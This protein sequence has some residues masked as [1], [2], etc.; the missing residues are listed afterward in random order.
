MRSLQYAALYILSAEIVSGVNVEVCRGERN[1]LFSNPDLAAS[2]PAMWKAY[3]DNCQDENMCEYV[4]EP[5]GAV[6]KVDFREMKDSSY[7]KNIKQTCK[8]LG[9][10]EYPTSLCH[11][12]SELLVTTNGVTDTFT[13]HG[14]PVCFAYQCHES[15]ADLADVKPLGCDES[16]GTCE[17]KK[18]VARCD[19][20]AD[21][22][23]NGNCPKHQETINSDQ[24]Y[25][26][27]KQM[28]DSEAG[29]ACI[30]FK[31][32]G[33]NPVCNTETDPVK[34]N[35]AENYRRFEDYDE[36][37]RFATACYDAGG[38]TCFLSSV[39][40][41]VGDVVF[42]SIDV[43]ADHNEYPMCF[44]DDSSV[45]SPEDKLEV[46][47]DLLGREIGKK[48]QKTALVGG[49]PGY[50]NR[51]L[52]QSHYEQIS[53]VVTRSLQGEYDGQE[54]P[55]DGMKECSMV[56]SDFYCQRPGG[57]ES[58]RPTKDRYSTSDAS[59]NNLATLTMAAAVVA[60]G[61]IL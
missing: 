32:D 54:C 35:I 10:D 7:Y 14:E 24:T 5:F 23:G 12:D 58:S 4:A 60:G 51:H 26:T 28:L 20:R 27:S 44:P 3:D 6:S 53:E 37:K 17:I 41:V 22:A 57:W 31:T 56:V 13:V 11:V 9:T 1:A 48:I 18:L 42:F 46:A 43:T 59:I 36:Y 38:E 8:A 21:G 29:M 34:L 40:R 19:D 47:K 49:S 25:I 2:T 50:G 61:I 39:S 55:Q 15:Q 33:D 52:S 45:C 16:Q 30:D